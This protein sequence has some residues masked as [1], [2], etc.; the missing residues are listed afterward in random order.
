MKKVKLKQLI[1]ETQFKL[2]ENDRNTYTVES[3]VALNLKGGI[4]RLCRRNIG[5]SVHGTPYMISTNHF[6]YVDDDTDVIE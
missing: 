2:S 4:E 6:V 1:T 5:K 3:L